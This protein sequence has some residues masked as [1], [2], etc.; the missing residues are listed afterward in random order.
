MKLLGIVLIVLGIVGLV[1]GG[2]QWTTTKKVVDMGSLQ[3]THDT[4]QSLP[5]PPIVGGLCL[6]AGAVLL[7]AGARQ[8]A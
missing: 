5:L 3:V 7:V 2:I 4:T 6:A 1:Y 8:K